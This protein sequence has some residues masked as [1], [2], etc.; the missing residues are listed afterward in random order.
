MRYLPDAPRGVM[1]YLFIELILWA[2]REGY[3][4]FNLGTAPL[5]GLEN[6]ALAPLW[7]RVG[8]FVFHH[9]EHFYNFQGLRD[10]KEKFDPEWEPKYLA[11]PGGLSLPRILTDIAALIGGGLKGVIRK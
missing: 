3:G 11:C 8:A 10:Y 7:N 9:G 5:S 2:R 4:Q 6:R 1:E